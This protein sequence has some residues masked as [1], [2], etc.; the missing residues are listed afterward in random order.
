MRLAAARDH[1]LIEQRRR[2]AI[3]PAEQPLKQSHL[4]FVHT[5]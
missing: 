3:G 4:V 1:R 5:S 2:A